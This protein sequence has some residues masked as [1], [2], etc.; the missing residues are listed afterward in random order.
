MSEKLTFDTGIREFEV[1]GNGL[2]RFNPSDPNVY[3]RF[4]ELYRD[5][6]NMEAEIGEKSGAAADGMEVVEL[7]AQYD[8]QVKEKLSYVFG[9]GND[10]DALLGG[11][12]LM[13]VTKSGNM[14]IVNL[15]NALRPIIEQG[16]RAYAKA[17]AAAEV[18][19]ARRERAAR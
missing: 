9:E 18:E 10:F 5:I 6:Q 12:N 15:L 14:V 1:N 19:K 3:K 11:V 16:V 4:K 17:Q 7:L 2:L 8:G 13:A